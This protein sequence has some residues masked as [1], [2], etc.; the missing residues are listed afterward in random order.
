[1]QSE[2]ATGR[3]FVRTWLHC[4]HLQS[5]GSKMAKSAG[6]IARVS[7]LLE[8]GVSARALRY[9]LIAVHYRAPLNYSDESQLAAT[10]A[11]DRLEAA[12]AALGAYREDRTPDP[13]LG[14]VL[15]AADGAFGEALDDDL[16]ISAA[17]AA[18]F[19]LVRDLNRRIDGRTLSTSDAERALALIR[20][21][22]QVLGVLPAADEDLD[23]ESRRMLDDRATARR[24]R[25]WAASPT[26]AATVGP[27]IVRSGRAEAI[28]QAA[29]RLI[30]AV[31]RVGS[32][33]DRGRDHLSVGS[34]PTPREDQRAIDPMPPLEVA[35][36][37]S[38]PGNVR[39]VRG[40]ATSGAPPTVH[41]LADP[42][43]DLDLARITCRAPG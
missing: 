22:D 13:E 9:A 33:A 3:P 31:R 27:R 29:G 6:N 34:G 20:S 25:D 8:A 1:A 2:A 4:A 36:L 16:N 26:V 18:V 5:S 32:A 7:D 19:D 43:D 23:E 42:A 35:A 15:A 17:L 37:P 39:L 30:V 41:A 10:A 12:V 11:L 21:F 28:R 40:R 38:D 24:N 14:D